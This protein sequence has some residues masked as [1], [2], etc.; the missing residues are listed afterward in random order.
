[1]NNILSRN[2]SR[3]AGTIVLITLIFSTGINACATFMYSDGDRHLV[4]RNLDQD[5]YT[6]GMIHI[7]LRGESKRSVSGYDLQITGIPST[8][9]NWT[10]KYGSV[11]F[12]LLGRGLP[13]GGIN[14][15][16]LTVNEMALASSE[17]RYDDTLPAMLSHQWIQYQLD[18]FATVEELVKN[19][20]LINAEPISTFTPVSWAKIHLFVAD[21]SG[22]Y[23]I[24]EFIDSSIVVHRGDTAPVPILCNY[25]Y[26]MELTRVKQFDGFFGWLRKTINPDYDMRFITV[27]NALIDSKENQPD[28]PGSFCFELLASIQ[29][30]S[31]KQWSM[32]YDLQKNRIMFR[33]AANTDLKFLNLSDIDFSS[34]GRSLILPDIDAELTGN[35][36]SELVDYTIDADRAIIG[37]FMTN[38]LAFVVEQNDLAGAD[39]YLM[40][41]FGFNLKQLIERAVKFGQ[42]TLN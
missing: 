26:K 11:T 15:A 2:S 12:S 8:I 33:T 23:A 17:F 28:D 9:L 37:K 22:D 16:G 30:E 4:A 6:P 35:I 29:N 13:D 32:V 7:N 19:L 25:E 14:E 40:E 21:K 3:I 36:A 10:S 38:L 42:K 34:G 41:Q 24:I 18:N 5:F 20:P 39:E 31:T 27:N 1:M